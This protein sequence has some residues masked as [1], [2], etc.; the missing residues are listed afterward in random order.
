MFR[1][2]MA[3]LAEVR[4]EVVS[5]LY[6]SPGDEEYRTRHFRSLVTIKAQI[7][8]CVC[9]QYSFF[10]VKSS[11][12]IILFYYF[13]FFIILIFSILCYNSFCYIVLSADNLKLLHFFCCMKL[14]SV[15]CLKKKVFLQ[16]SFFF[17]REI[18][19][20]QGKRNKP[21]MRFLGGTANEEGE[22]MR[23]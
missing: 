6:R 20:Q 2:N 17:N 15:H 9:V 11:F 13:L 16:L 18:Q 3:W 4:R 14:V 1:G 21:E 5:H 22:R 8:T 23:T 10:K 7:H 12:F 19:Q